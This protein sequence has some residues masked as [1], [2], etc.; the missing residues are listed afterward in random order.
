MQQMYPLSQF[1]LIDNKEKEE[2]TK[3]KKLNDQ[4]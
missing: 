3:I 4:K 1:K 2:V